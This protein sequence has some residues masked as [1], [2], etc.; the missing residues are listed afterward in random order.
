MR[1]IKFSLDDEIKEKG[2]NYF[3]K[4]YNENIV[5]GLVLDNTCLSRDTL[6]CRIMELK[7]NNALKQWE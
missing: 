2:K 6:Y 3:Y 4:L 7:I 1:I 5:R